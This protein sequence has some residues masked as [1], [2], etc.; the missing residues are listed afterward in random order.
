MRHLLFIFLISGLA[1]S[2]VKQQTKDPIPLI[3][4][5][6]FL[7]PGKSP[8]TQRDT[9][10][11]YITYQDG[12]GDLFTDTRNEGPNFIF[13]PYFYNT[14]TNQFYVEIDPIT[15]DTFRI[16]NTILQP[17]NGY[18]KG[19]SIKGEIFVPLNQFRKNDAVKI[20]KFKGF[21]I[22]MKAHKSNVVSSPVYTLNF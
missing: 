1:Y 5:K 17:D 9:A 8:Y 18:Y 10:L 11:I 20:L 2:C 3:E 22:D 4:F 6:D 14:N 19:K 7:N 21:M 15:N 16:T 13:T 12:D